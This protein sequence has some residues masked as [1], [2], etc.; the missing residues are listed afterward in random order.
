MMD[1]RLKKLDQIFDSTVLTTDNQFNASCQL[2]ASD[3]YNRQALKESC[4][5]N[6]SATT[7]KLYD[8]GEVSP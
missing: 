6:F 7:A 8:N 3:I 5:T 4:K 1:A 2:D